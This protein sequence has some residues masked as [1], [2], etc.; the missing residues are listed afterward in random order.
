MTVEKQKA[1]RLEEEEVKELNVLI[2]NSPF[3][4]AEWFRD[5]LTKAK[6]Y[7]KATENPNLQPN[8]VE[9]AMLLKRQADVFNN[10]LEKGLDAIEVQK[11]HIGKGLSDKDAI[12]EKL[13][14]EI[15]NL[16]K[17]IENYKKDS[18]LHLKELAETQQKYTDLLDSLKAQ[19]ELAEQYKKQAEQND[20]YRNDYLHEVELHKQLKQTY[21]EVDKKAKATVSAF[22]QTLTRQS[23]EMNNVK[24]EKDRMEENVDRLKETHQQQLNIIELKH[25]NKM[26]ELQNEKEKAIQYN[27]IRVA[28]AVAEKAV[29]HSLHAKELI[30]LITG[31]RFEELLNRSEGETKERLTKIASGAE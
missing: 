20:R 29:D 7:E 12:I 1:F 16:H 25:Q 5:M 31:I 24:N 19:T 10:F 30:E 4:D 21:L 11:A 27:Q 22:E 8:I 13:E 17:S 9:M 6:L 3:K 18:T 23:H 28:L 14:I 26:L 15:Q 2:A